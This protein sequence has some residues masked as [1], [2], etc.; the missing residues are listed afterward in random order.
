VSEG[1]GE[2]VSAPAPALGL[3]QALDGL[4]VRLAALEAVAAPSP[5]MPLDV[6]LANM[7]TSV[8]L[9]MDL[10][11]PRGLHRCVDGVRTWPKSECYAC[12]EVSSLRGKP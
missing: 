3:N 12:K 7:N 8:E 6:L 2:A 11:A 10:V 9:L 4:G 5:D 1:D